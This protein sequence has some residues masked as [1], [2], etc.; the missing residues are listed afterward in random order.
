MIERVVPP[1]PEGHVRVRAKVAYDGGCFSGFAKS[2]GVVTVQGE[3]ETALAQVLRQPTPIACAGRTDR[4]V[5]ARGQVVSFD[6]EV[7][8]FDPLA[9]RRAVNRIVKPSIVI[10]DVRATL[11]NFDARLS[12]IG[13]T[14]RYTILHRDVPDPLLENLVWHR[15]GELDEGLLQQAADQVV[16]LHDFSAFSKRN[17]SR[18]VETFM[19]RIHKA[20]WSRHGELLR[21]E[22]AGKAFTHQMVRSLV[23]LFVD[24][25]RGR[26][27]LEDV[28]AA[29][30]QSTRDQKSSPAPPHGLVLW[31]V[32]YPDPLQ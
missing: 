2:P 21:L 14:Y 5:H 8:H 9:L 19:R 31:S 24:I 17:K 16:G 4:G 22:I 1:P 26:R 12:C 27:P 10:D 25:A 20:Q 15:S 13:R 23:A 28:A 3:L 7:G 29:L 18:P 32:T 6:A 30:E 11:P